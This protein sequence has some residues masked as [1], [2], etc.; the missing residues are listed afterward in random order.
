LSADMGRESAPP[1]PRGM[2]RLMLILASDECECECE[3]EY[4]CEKVWVW[5]PGEEATDIEFAERTIGERGI[6]MEP[7]LDVETEPDPPI[8]WLRD[9]RSAVMDGETARRFAELE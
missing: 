5:L 4:G 6:G 2:G 3:C 8:A 7:E 9:S 1:K